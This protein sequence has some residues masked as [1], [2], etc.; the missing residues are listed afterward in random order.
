MS[1]RRSA[2]AT[3]DWSETEH[4]TCGRVDPK[5]NLQTVGVSAVESPNVAWLERHRY[6]GAWLTEQPRAHVKR[7]VSLASAR[8]TAHAAPLR[9]YLPARVRREHATRE[10]RLLDARSWTRPGRQGTSAKHH[11]NTSA[12]R[13][14]GKAWTW[15]SGRRRHRMWVAGHDHREEGRRSTAIR[16]VGSTGRPNFPAPPMRQCPRLGNSGDRLQPALH[17]K[18]SLHSLNHLSA[19]SIATA[20]SDPPCFAA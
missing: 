9:S 17:S 5:A 6:L 18:D 15:S 20:E 13:K 12:A 4:Q 8:G 1:R 11:A 7:W 19:R 2:F 14:Y 10:R 3:S 16:A